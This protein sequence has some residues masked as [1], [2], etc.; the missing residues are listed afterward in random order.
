MKNGMKLNPM[1]SHT[2]VMPIVFAT[3]GIN[4]GYNILS[5][6]TAIARDKS[7]CPVDSYTADGDQDDTRIRIGITGHIVK[8]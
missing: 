1:A 3:T 6:I 2:P 7:K 5:G 8:R 4:S